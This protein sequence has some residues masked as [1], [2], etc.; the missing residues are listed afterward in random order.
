MAGV[1][2][3][4]AV[5]TS[6]F[7]QPLPTS[8]I[9]PAPGQG[10]LGLEIRAGDKL[11]QQVAQRINSQKS[12]LCVSCERV[13][14]RELGGGCRLPLGAWAEIKNRQIHLQVM[15][16]DRNGKKMVRLSQ[17]AYFRQGERMG[18]ELANAVLKEG[19]EQMFK[20]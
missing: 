14:L 10:A 18:K 15:A 12:F 7:I 4:G 1:I 6:L 19:G 8:L 9:L 17:K 11:S 16:A 5:P 20:E 13:F 3:L 2:R